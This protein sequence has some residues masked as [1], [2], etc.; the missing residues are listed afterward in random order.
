MS[1]GNRMDTLAH[2]PHATF[3][4]AASRRDG[5]SLVEVVVAMVM[6]SVVISSLAML[7][8]VTAQRSIGLANETTRQA[9]SLQETNRYS[10][11]AYDSLAGKVGCDTATQ[12]GLSYRRCMSLTTGT[13][14]KEVTV[15]VTPLRTGTYADTVI[16]RRVASVT[17]N[18][19]FLP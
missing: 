3:A 14:Y 17:T 5:F 10:A 11:M 19:L 9:Y 13:R 1:K 15:I 4:P 12:S 16:F 2:D 6:L 7:T 8:T 18:P